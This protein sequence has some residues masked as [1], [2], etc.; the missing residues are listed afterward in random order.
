MVHGG[1][2]DA[3]GENSVPSV[4]PKDICEWA[5]PAVPCTPSGLGESPSFLLSNRES[6]D[7]WPSQSGSLSVKHMQGAAVDGMPVTHLDDAHLVPS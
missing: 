1:R 6:A 2:K 3:Q 5:V 7:R 4:P